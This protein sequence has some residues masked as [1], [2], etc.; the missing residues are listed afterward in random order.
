MRSAGLVAKTGW[1]VAVVLDGPA[2]APSVLD[3]LRIELV[4]S[5]LPANVYHVALDLD[6][7]AGERLVA[8]VQKCADDHAATAVTELAAAFHV[9]AIG[10]VAASGTVPDQLSAILA[11]HTLVHAAEGELIRD[12]LNSGALAAG[13]PVVRTRQKD[14]VVAAS[15]A[16][17]LDEHDLRARLVELGRPLGAPW[18]QEQKDAALAAWLALAA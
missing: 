10:L 15:T 18:R 16:L 4:P 9:K 5:D 11:S 12:A 6:A 3:R 2:D 13:L 8:E 7:V 1:A 14:L 17:G